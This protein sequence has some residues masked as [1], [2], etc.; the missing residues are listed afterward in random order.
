MIEEK[1]VTIRQC[2]SKSRLPKNIKEEISARIGSR[3]KKGTRDVLIG[4]SIEE[5]GYI[6]PLVILASEENKD[7][8]WRIQMRNFYADLVIDVPYMKGLLLNIATEKRS[9]KD[10]T[11]GKMVEVEAFPVEPMDYVMYKQCI[12]DN[13][14]ATTDHE[15]KYKGNFKFYLEDTNKAKDLAR[16]VRISLN[17]ID[18]SYLKLIA[19]DDKTSKFRD[20]KKLDAVLRLLNASAYVTL[21]DEDKIEK[22]S[23]LRDVAKDLV[24]NQQTELSKVPFQNIINDS[25]LG[26]KSEI[27]MMVEIGALEQVNTYYRIPDTDTH[28]GANMKEAVLFIKDSNNSEVISKLRYK[29]TG[30]PV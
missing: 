20:E 6:L 17:E 3:F 16:K 7:L 11:S 22:L 24:S 12:A 25:D 13:R 18:K 30:S 14:V 5:R 8:D 23:E 26:I 15:I 28:V 9:V 2:G 19:I 21:T 4:L 27:M 1:F 10:I 29:V